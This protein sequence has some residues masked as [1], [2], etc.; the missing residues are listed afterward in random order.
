MSRGSRFGARSRRRARTEAFVNA[1]TK[2]LA[3]LGGPAGWSEAILEARTPTVH[4]K[5]TEQDAAER[6]KPEC[7]P[8]A[9][10]LPTEQRRQE[11]VP[12]LPHYEAADR[13]ECN[14]SQQRQRG[15]EDPFLSHLHGV[16]LSRSRRRSLAIGGA[17]TGRRNACVTAA[18]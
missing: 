3:F 11:P 13:G 17:D 8:E 14:H 15:N 16:I 5:S 4:S 2:M 1:A 9:D 18:Y 10:P 6:Q 7:L 12:Q